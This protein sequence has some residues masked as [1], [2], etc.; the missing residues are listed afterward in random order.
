MSGAAHQATQAF[1]LVTERLLIFGQLTGETGRLRHH[2]AAQAE[3]NQEPDED[4]HQ[5]R[6]RAWNS[7]RMKTYNKRRKDKAQENRQ[8]DRYKDFTAEVERSDDQRCDSQINQCRAARLCEL[9][10]IGLFQLRI[11]SRNGAATISPPAILFMALH[12]VFRRFQCARAEI[13]PIGTRARD[14]PG[15]IPSALEISASVAF[16][17]S[18]TWTPPPNK[19]PP[20]AAEHC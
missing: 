7:Q 12:C 9:Y 5:D 3:Y 19:L 10:L 1:D 17:A 16:S 14:D 15:Q 2:Q 11:L 20:S 4:D 18:L 13:V 6:N 8:R